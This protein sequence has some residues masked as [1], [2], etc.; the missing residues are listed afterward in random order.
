MTA[1]KKVHEATTDLVF[2]AS[3]RRPTMEPNVEAKN[4]AAVNSTAETPSGL[5]VFADGKPKL[6][7]IR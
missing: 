2:S 3:Q 4:C 6:K 7:T 1:P 5:R